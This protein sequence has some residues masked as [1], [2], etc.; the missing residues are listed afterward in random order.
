MYM[1]DTRK[2]LLSFTPDFVETIQTELFPSLT[3]TVLQAFSSW[4]NHPL[5]YYGDGVGC[6]QCKSMM[7][8][9]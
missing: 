9:C 8:T 4:A 2:D 1:Q 6:L 7:M 5:A 3:D